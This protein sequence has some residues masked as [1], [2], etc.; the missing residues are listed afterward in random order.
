MEIKDKPKNKLI[1]LE[2][3]NAKPMLPVRVK[4][5]RIEMPQLDLKSQ[6][7]EK[8]SISFGMLFSD[9]TT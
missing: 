5:A 1:Q 7:S 4:P 2:I 8:P 6:E 3:M 9:K